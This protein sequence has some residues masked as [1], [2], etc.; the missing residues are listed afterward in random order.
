AG[1]VTSTGL[2][3]AN[4][5]ASNSLLEGLVFGTACAH[6]AVAMVNR[7]PDCFT[8]LPL[9]SKF[10]PD[11]EGTLDA[12]DITN[13][14]RSM[15]VRHMG[16]IREHA[17]LQQAQHDVGFWCR[18][19][20]PHEFIQRAGWELQNLLTIAR[21]MIH[22]ALAREESRGV[23]YRGDFPAADDAKWLRHVVCP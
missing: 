9:A 15:M 17:G 20:L 18:Y 5:L 7:M 2:H 19:V 22:S 4:R 3:G 16:V 6:G 10:E 23:H 1:E 12:V 13:S 14:L 8:A 21:L 11:A